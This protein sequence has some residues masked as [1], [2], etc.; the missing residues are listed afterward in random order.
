VH[1]YLVVLVRLGLG[2]TWIAAGAAKLA[3]KESVRDSVARFGLVPDRAAHAVAIVLP[4]I[5]LSLGALLI[6]GQWT[7]PLANASISLLFVFSG[8]IL[9]NLL[10]GNR[11]ACHCFGQFGGKPISWGALARNL[12][13]LA[14]ASLVSVR[15]SGYLAA[16][17]WWHGSP[18]AADPPVLDFVPV[19]LIAVGI[20][21]LSILA[22]SAWRAARTIMGA[23]EAL[24]LAFA[25]HTVWRQLLAMVLP[26]LARNE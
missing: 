24:G 8:A 17:G 5:E 9:V 2:A 10:R 18:S 15:H 16:D 25:E 6:V 3:S 7:K 23:N 22:I 4:W 14:A 13:L 21:L 1:P 19:V 20:V 12:V 11:I 26:R